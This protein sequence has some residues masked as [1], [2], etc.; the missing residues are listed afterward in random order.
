M[1]HQ[2][3]KVAFT[4]SMRNLTLPFIRGLKKG[5]YERLL[6]EDKIAA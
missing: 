6:M 5:T 3:S 4:S 1:E 2:I